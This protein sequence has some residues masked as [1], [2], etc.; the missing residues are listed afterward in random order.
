MCMFP[1]ESNSMKLFSR[2]TVETSKFPPVFQCYLFCDMKYAV[3]SHPQEM[4]IS[5]PLSFSAVYIRHLPNL[6]AL[7][8]SFCPL[9]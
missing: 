1:K 5:L 9:F 6:S 2:G 7:L 4:N 8:M 3:T